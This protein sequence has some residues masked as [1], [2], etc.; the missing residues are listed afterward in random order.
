MK[1]T[2]G[3]PHRQVSEVPFWTGFRSAENK[4]NEKRDLRR[5]KKSERWDGE[6][7]KSWI[8]PILFLILRCF[9]RFISC[10]LTRCDVSL[11]CLSSIVMFHN[12][13][14]PFIRS[15]V[16][17]VI[18]ATKA[19][20]SSSRKASI[21]SQIVHCATVLMEASVNPESRLFPEWDRIFT[22]GSSA[23]SKSSIFKKSALSSTIIFVI[24]RIHCIISPLLRF[25]L[26][27]PYR[28]H[29][30]F[31]QEEYVFRPSEPEEFPILIILIYGL[32]IS[33]GS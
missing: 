5:E 20:K 11:S 10:L 21:E 16:F 22:A 18:N 23:F 7:T 13:R 19:D 9:C 25:P 27:I 33:H 28:E 31:F 29:L 32:N 15:A 6:I 3:F 2:N 4:W 14:N 30:H 12:Y 8:T 24:S 26:S 1:H 17:N